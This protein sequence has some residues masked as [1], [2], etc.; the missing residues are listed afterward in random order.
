MY[1]LVPVHVMFYVKFLYI[2]KTVP[3]VFA[4]ME[5]E[6]QKQTGKTRLLT[7]VLSHSQ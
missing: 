3:V 4:L 7:V 1:C 5:K 2:I 6:A